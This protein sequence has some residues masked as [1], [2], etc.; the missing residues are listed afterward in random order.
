MG[1]VYRARDRKLNR[2]V[3]IKI[4]P[5]ELSRDPSRV[6][7]F[8]REAEA[9]ASLNH[10]SIGA[11]YNL[12]EDKGVR[13]LV[14]EFI[15]GETLADRIARGPIP[16]KEAVAIVREVAEALEAAH[17]QAITHRDIKPANIMLTKR[18][19]VKV[20][21]FGLAK[22]TH[23]DDQTLGSTLTAVTQSGSVM[24]TVHYMSPEQVL[25][26]EVDPRTDLFSLGVVFCEMLTGCLSFDGASL[27]QTMDQIVHAEPKGIN[28][29][30]SPQ[31]A[32]IVRRCV[33]KDPERRYASA[34]DL[35]K[36][37]EDL[38]RDYHAERAAWNG[39]AKHRWSIGVAAFAIAVAII[40]VRWLRE[41]PR[42]LS[43]AARDWM[44][45]SDMNNQTG[46]PVFDKSLQT[47]LLIGLEQSRY[48]NVFPST[49]ISES[50][51]RMNKTGSEPIDEALGRDIALREGIRALIVP[52]INSVGDSYLL[53]ARIEDPATGKDVRTEQ[54]RANGKNKVLPAVDDLIAKV[55]VDL[56]ES[57]PALAET[58]KPL[59]KVTTAS[60]EALKLFSLGREKHLGSKFDEAKT[61][62][63]NAIRIDPDFMAAKGQLGVL[64]FE[65]YDREQ[66]KRLLSETIQSVDGLTDREKYGISA[67]YAVAVENDLPKAI[68][69]NK[70]LLALHP[71]EWNIYN[72]VGWYSY[73][74]GKGDDAVSA[75][76]EAIRLNPYAMIS[77]NGFV[78]VYLYL[79]GVLDAALDLCRKQIAYDDR[80]AFAHENMGWALLGKGDLAAARQSFQK[81]LEIDESSSDARL[82]LGHTYLLEGR[83]RDAAAMYLSIPRYKPNE[84]YPY[85]YAGL[86]CEF[87]KDTVCER[88]NL[89]KFIGEV[90]NRIKEKPK[91]PQYRLALA[92]AFIR[93][94]STA[95]AQV[96]ARTAIQMAPDRHFEIAQLLSAQGKTDEAVAQ[97]ELAVQNDFHDYVALKAHPD[98]QTLQNLPRFRELVNAH[99]KTGGSHK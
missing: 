99:L 45:V 5:T 32:K 21:D 43:F 26:R 30:G 70:L 35:L 51:K 87:G 52:S 27:G 71:D 42:V 33:E 66:G 83:Y 49:R 97:I 56:G 8:Q 25:G 44:L 95:E 24:G 64:L 69:L 29:I 31:L 16:D 23:L 22:M 7:R 19:H 28:L 76:K 2:E 3:A 37:L 96:Q 85:Y 62:Y 74:L 98:L 59:D 15:A 84:Y 67:F 13:F 41:T 77:Y 50:L 94:G 36:D 73:Q 1:E 14:L 58:T 82:R 89:R 18:M 75:Y 61:Y 80:I 40:V 34:H 9:L 91:D 55:R 39:I 20:L 90:N 68:Q 4:L 47:A 48:A 86:A 10:R 63:E 11:L 54:V 72:N 88:A 65:H 53:A 6:K 92:K 81:A 60:L 78:M 46:D 79:L 38:G 93:T 12:E 17:D 57:L